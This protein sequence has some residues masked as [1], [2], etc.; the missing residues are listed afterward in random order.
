M[1]L[2]EWVTSHTVVSP[3]HRQVHDSGRELREFGWLMIPDW[4][5]GTVKCGKAIIGGV[6]SLQVKFEC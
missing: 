3:L 1:L 6:I 2:E 5:G 4:S